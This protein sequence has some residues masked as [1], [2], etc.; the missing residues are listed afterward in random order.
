GAWG[1][2]LVAFLLGEF[3]TARDQ[4]ARAIAASDEAIGPLLMRGQIALAT[5][6]LTALEHTVAE[7]A[8]RSPRAESLPAWQRALD[9]LRRSLAA[10]A[11]GTY[12]RLIAFPTTMQRR[13]YCG[14]CTVELVLRY[15]RGGLDM[16]NDQIA[17]V[18]K[19]PDN[20]T[21]IYKMREFFHL[22]GFDTLRCRASIGQLKRL[23][24]AGYPVIVEEEFPNSAHVVVVIGYDDAVNV[25]IFQ[26]PMTHIIT[27][28]PLDAVNRLRRPSLDATLV[29]FP[30][31]Q[32][33][34]KTLALMDLFDDQAL[35][36]ADQASL[37]LDEGRPREAAALAAQAAAR[38]PAFRRAWDLRL[39]AELQ[40]WRQARHT[41][42]W[43]EGSIAAR[44]AHLRADDPAA[45]RERA[46][47]ALGQAAQALPDAASTHQLAGRAAVLDSDLRRALESLQRA[48]ELEPDHA[49][50][51][52]LVSECY[53]A[54]RDRDQALE[55][56]ERAVACDPALAA[57][58]A[59]MARCLAP[60]D[61][62]RAN[63]YARCAAEQAPDW[64][65]THLALAEVQI[66]RREINL[67]RRAVGVALGLAP[68]EPDVRACFA[69]ILALQGQIVEAA[70]EIEALLAT[71]RPLSPASA[72]AARQNL[73]RILFGAELYDQAAVRAQELL[74]LAPEDPWALQH[75]AA[76]R[77]GAHR[78]RLG[79]RR[80]GDRRNPAA[81]RACAGGQPGRSVHRPRLSR[82]SGLAGGPGY[83]DRRGCR[84]T[85]SVSAARAGLYP[86]TAA[87]AGQAGQ[88][89]RRGDARRADAIR[90][91]H[92]QRRPLPGHRG[93]SGWA[94]PGRRRAN[95]AR[96]AGDRG[97]RTTRH[98]RAGAWPAARPA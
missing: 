68:E 47:M 24:D 71:E 53:F 72:Y 44:L 12:A 40:R 66:A 30:A 36:W 37:A 58:N 78:R 21:P 50:T 45:A 80:G 89:G 59:W 22:V 56:A 32:G 41:R 14:P 60:R 73:C 95:G 19:F 79:R 11:D 55:A 54:L 23:I 5:N 74:A 8:R 35:V 92:R 77:G 42:A 84:A 15:W 10:P 98:A 52:A 75:H 57:A 90:G 2:A 20:G 49:R 91:D 63:H 83:G 31:G 62:E 18:V 17:Q 6:D 87:D 3:E 64:W 16:T 76:A 33:H 26:D 94:R 65:L 43:P 48:R 97:G 85:R 13:D 67:A 93:D 39:L 86:W 38:Q 88:A 46:Y 81:L 7:L 25:L 1:L 28:I 51:L 34:D 70:G 9:D 96:P 69:T 29:A 4:I 82:V 61:P 27:R